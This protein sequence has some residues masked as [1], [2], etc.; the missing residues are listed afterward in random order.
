MTPAQ[1]S[2]VFFLQLFFILAVCRFVGMLARRL[3]QPQVVGEMIAGVVMGPSL[4]GNR[5]RSYMSSRSSE[6]LMELIIGVWGATEPLW[7]AFHKCSVAPQT[8]FTAFC[9]AS[10]GTDARSGVQAKTIWDA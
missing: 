1:L 9:Q 5:L 3:G 6:G 7:N 2:A 10:S 8:P 4:F